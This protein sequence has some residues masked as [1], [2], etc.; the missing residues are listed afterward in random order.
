MKLT[1]EDVL[2]FINELRKDEKLVREFRTLLFSDIRIPNPVNPHWSPSLQ[3]PYGNPP[4]WTLTDPSMQPRQYP[5]YGYGI[6]C[7]PHIGGSISSQT[8]EPG[9]FTWN[10]DDKYTTFRRV[11]E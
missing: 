3:H 1:R 9:T 4:Q 10:D 2:D 11:E 7:Q 5:P 6:T 8:P